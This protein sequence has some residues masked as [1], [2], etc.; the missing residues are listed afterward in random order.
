MEKDCQVQLT[1][2]RN[3]AVRVDIHQIILCIELLFGV[4]YRC[5]MVPNTVQSQQ[6]YQ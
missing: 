6:N 3:G 4:C 5:F 1:E 2:Q